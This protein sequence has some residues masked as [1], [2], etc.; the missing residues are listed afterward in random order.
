MARASPR[1]DKHAM[2]DMN[3]S[4]GA[5]V[6]ICEDE[7]ALATVLR[8]KLDRHGFTV[9][10]ASDGVEAVSKIRE[11]S[12]DIVLLDLIMPNKNGFQVLEEVKAD[13]ATANVKIIVFSNLN[14]EEDRDRARKLGAIDF[15][16]KSDI[17][18]ND[19][20]GKIQLHLG[21]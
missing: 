11:F 19:V 7:I 9:A 13:P 1:P 18:I 15:W 3:T 10:V 14:Q 6:L 16:V 2:D 21:S 12:P 20:I 5:K 8:N 17:A 4:Q